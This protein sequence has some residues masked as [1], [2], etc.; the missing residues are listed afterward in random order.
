MH[1]RLGRAIPGGFLAGSPAS[2]DHP[3]TKLPG[4]LPATR[5]Q[6]L[7]AAALPLPS[8][9]GCCTRR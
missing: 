3:G 8:L 5:E 7:E 4:C 1:L 2:R 9:Q 6:G